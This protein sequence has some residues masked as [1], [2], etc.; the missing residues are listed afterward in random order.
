MSSADR[1]DVR[2]SALGVTGPMSSTW[3]SERRSQAVIEAALAAGITCFDTGAFYGAGL[4]EKR[5]ASVLRARGAQ[6]SIM[7]KVGKRAGW[8][9]RL[10]AAF[11][12]DAIRHDV[13]TS[14]VRFGCE[15]LDI[16][17]LHGPSRDET[18]IGLETLFRLQDEGK[19][20]KVG[21]CTTANHLD[22]AVD[23]GVEAVMVAFNFLDARAVDAMQLAKRRDIHVA[24]I[25]PLA[26][27]VYEPDYISSFA[28]SDMWKSLRARRNTPQLVANAS[29]VRQSLENATAVR[30]LSVAALSYV[31]SHEFVDVA[32]FTTTKPSRIATLA[33]AST[34]DH[35]EIAR[36]REIGRQMSLF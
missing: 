26:Q 31:L 16:V 21:I 32:V 12:P 17:Y 29:K 22:A 19:I 30:P 2:R 13:D 7:T 36:L 20:G 9:G 4:A 33:N 3:F 27:G 25:A 8:N 34:M 15:R 23:S 35:G 14:L 11:S 10:R 28:I 1:I 6:A 18:S 24:A 5:L